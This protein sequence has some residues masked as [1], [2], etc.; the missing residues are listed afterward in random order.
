MTLPGNSGYRIPG[1]ES[2]GFRTQDVQSSGYRIPGNQFSGFQTQ[3]VQSSGYQIPDATIYGLG[4][5]DRLNM[6]DASLF[7][8]H[9]SYAVGGGEG[10]GAI[11]A[12]NNNFTAEPLAESSA[13]STNSLRCE[14]QSDVYVTAGGD[15]PLNCTT[16]S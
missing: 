6:R 2:S 8:L 3:A 14:S 11:V 10:G 15:T 4:G 13:M 1:G 16:G 7:P 5:A 9:G 12:S